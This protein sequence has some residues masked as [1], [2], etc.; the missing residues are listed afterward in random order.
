MQRH[1]CD[2]TSYPIPHEYELHMA[3]LVRGGDLRGTGSQSVTEAGLA[4][5]LDE[6]LQW[7]ELHQEAGLARWSYY[8][9]RR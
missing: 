5:L 6:D 1:R 7:E 3:A 4:N 2:R 8:L 9:Y